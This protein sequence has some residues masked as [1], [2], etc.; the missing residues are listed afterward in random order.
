MYASSV[1]PCAGV[2]VLCK[3]MEITVYIASHGNHAQRHY[4]TNST[5]A[6]YCY[7]N[8]VVQESFIAVA[9]REHFLLI[10]GFLG[11]NFIDLLLPLAIC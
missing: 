11:R 5:S 3:S 7:V 4:S 10:Y 1:Y 6:I 9:N 8:I 2:H